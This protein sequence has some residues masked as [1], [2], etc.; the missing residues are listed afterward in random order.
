MSHWYVSLSLERRVTSRA[1][2]LAGTLAALAVALG[3]CGQDRQDENE[4]EGTYKVDVVSASFPGRQ[5]LARGGHAEDRDPE[6]GLARDPEPGRDGGRLRPAARGRR[7]R[8]PGAAGV[9]PERG[10]ATT[11][12][13]RSR[14]PG[15]SARCRPAQTRTLELEGDRRARGHVQPALPRGGRARRQGERRVVRRQRPAKGSFIA[16]I[17]RAPA[18]R[19]NRTERVAS[20]PPRARAARPRSRR[21]APRPNPA[22]RHPAS[23]ARGR[24]ASGARER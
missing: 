21:S 15:P 13:P 19:S 12:R 20:G 22:A 23:R 9:D 2:V 14:T 7:P 11:R 10:A 3:A 8:R 5:R 4:P 17:T 18:R 24:R 6:Q 1:G 16:R